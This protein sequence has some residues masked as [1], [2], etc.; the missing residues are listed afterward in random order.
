MVPPRK[1]C[2]NFVDKIFDALKA[3]TN[4]APGSSENVEALVT[5]LYCILDV[6]KRAA[7]DLSHMKQCLTLDVSL[8]EWQEVQWRQWMV[9]FYG[10]IRG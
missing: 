1:Y 3:T 2:V 6:I 7:A 8:Q 4:N 10:E 5:D 9:H